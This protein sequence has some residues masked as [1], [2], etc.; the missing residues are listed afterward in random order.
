MSKSDRPCRENRRKPYPRC[1]AAD[2][3]GCGEGVDQLH[4]HQGQNEIGDSMTVK[5]MPLWKTIGLYKTKRR[6][7]DDLYEPYKPE[8]REIYRKGVLMKRF[9]NNAHREGFY[10]YRGNS[11][12]QT[13]GNLY[14]KTVASLVS[15]FDDFFRD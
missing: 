6:I 14:G 1:R 12:F 2:K 13:K 10:C 8:H 7:N 4:R 11:F 9:E 5:S 3:K 15:V